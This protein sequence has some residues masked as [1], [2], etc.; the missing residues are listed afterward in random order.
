MHKAAIDSNDVTTDAEIIIGNIQI[1]T[2]LVVVFVVFLLPG[3]RPYIENLKP[4][5]FV[6]PH[7]D[8]VKLQIRHGRAWRLLRIVY[9]DAIQNCFPGNRMVSNIASF[10]MN[11]ESPAAMFLWTTTRTQIRPRAQDVC[12]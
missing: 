2:G 9:R 5:P 7:A 3:R 4:Y 12:L 6:T 11:H 10:I 8:M 1:V